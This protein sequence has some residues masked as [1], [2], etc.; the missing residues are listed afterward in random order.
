VTRW[1]YASIVLTL[2]A[3]AASLYLYFFQFDRLPPR[4]PT[5]WNAAG[6]VDGWTPKQDIFGT[7]LLVPAL[8]AGILVLTPL[9]PWLSPRHFEI[10]RFRQTYG[11]IMFLLTGLCAYIHLTILLGS[12]MI[13]VDTTKMVLG[14]ICL[15]LAAL[16][17]VMGKVRRNFYV[18]VR[19]PWTLAS[20]AVWEP[21]HRLAAWLMVTGGI[22][23]FVGIVAGIPFYWC[24]IG[25]MVLILIPVPYSLILYKRL[26]RQGKLSGPEPC[27]PSQ[28]VPVS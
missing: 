20:D 9:L 27:N 12:L 1:F 17:N 13:P 25:L 8:M 19:T 26:E 6:E 7:F 4:L 3:L 28:E 14:G 22:L 21:T 24:F 15:F 10:D 11:Y 23:A 5:H 2:L 18:G 16:G